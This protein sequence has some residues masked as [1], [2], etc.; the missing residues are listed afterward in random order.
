MNP[1]LDFF[2]ALTA[3]GYTLPETGVRVPARHALDLLR[4][5]VT[6]SLLFLFVLAADSALCL[7]DAIAGFL[8]ALVS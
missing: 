6:F 5:L 1:A 2:I 7:G 4:A 3:L 8:S